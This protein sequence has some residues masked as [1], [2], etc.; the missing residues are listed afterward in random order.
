MK[1]IFEEN[2]YRFGT[3]LFLL[4]Y[5]YKYQFIL[6]SD[7]TYSGARSASDSGQKVE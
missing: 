5:L 7:F 3:E 1:N 6:G 2:K 4:M